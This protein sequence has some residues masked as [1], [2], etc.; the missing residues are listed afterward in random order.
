MKHLNLTLKIVLIASSLLLFDYVV[1]NATESNTSHVPI[2]EQYMIEYGYDLNAIHSAFEDKIINILK[3]YA[4]CDSSEFTEDNKAIWFEY[5]PTHYDTTGMNIYNNYELIDEYLD[6]IPM[7]IAFFASVVH[8]LTEAE[9]FEL[10]TQAD[11]MADVLDRVTTLRYSLYGPVQDNGIKP[12]V[13][14]VSPAG[15]IYLWIVTLALVAS[16]IINL[17]QL[18]YIRRK[19][20]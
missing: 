7:D 13:S 8:N 14:H 18:L 5:E 10:L 16:F 12:L 1:A 9:V 20:Q 17:I 4:L 2:T 3:P 6:A 15:T 11:V 19:R